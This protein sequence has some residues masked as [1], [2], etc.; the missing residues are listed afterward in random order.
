MFGWIITGG[1]LLRE[2]S[3]EIESGYRK[4][5]RQSESKVP[6]FQWIVTAFGAVMFMVALFS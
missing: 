5:D 2:R 1:L 3:Q 6:M 4:E